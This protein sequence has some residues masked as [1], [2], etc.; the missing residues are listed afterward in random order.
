MAKGVVWMLTVATLV[1]REIDDSIMQ[2][3]VPLL[4]HYLSVVKQRFRTWRKSKRDFGALPEARGSIAAAAASSGKRADM[5]RYKRDV[6]WSE[7]GWERDNETGET[8]SKRSYAWSTATESP[9]ASASVKREPSGDAEKLTPKE[10]DA[11][12]RN[13]GDTEIARIRAL[14]AGQQAPEPAKRGRGRPKG[15]VKKATPEV[16]IVPKATKKL[17]KKAS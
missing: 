16:E 15:S 5:G 17:T 7:T 11:E 10:Q 3:I 8:A 12:V 13:A 2:N 9:S 4:P 1:Y 6:V 14:I